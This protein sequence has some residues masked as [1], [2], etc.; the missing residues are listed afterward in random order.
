MAERTAPW[1]LDGVATGSQEARLFTE[2]LLDQVGVVGANDLKVSAPGGMNVSIAAGRAFIRDTTAY[3]GAYHVVADSATTR[4]VSAANATNP[5]RD[6]V[7]AEVTATS[8]QT[9]VVAGVAAASPVDPA[10]PVDAIVLARVTVP[11]AAAAITTA[12]IEDLRSF[13]SPIR[14]LLDRRNVI[15]NGDMSIWQRGA[16]SFTAQGYCADGW[17]KEHAG[18]TVSVGRTYLAPNVLSATRY[19]LTATV[20]GQAAATDYAIIGQRI[21]QVE[22]L[23]GKQVTISFIANATSAAKVALEALQVFGTGGAPSA[24]VTTPLGV[25][26]IGTAKARYAVTVTIPSIVGKSLG[27]NGDDYLAIRLYLSGGASTGAQGIG[28]QN[29]T[30]DVTDFQVEEGPVATPFERLPYQQQLAWCQRYFYRFIPNTSS[31][32]YGF[33]VASGGVGRVGW[34]HP[35]QMRAVPTVTFVGAATGWSIIRPSDGAV[36]DPN[37][38]YAGAGDIYGVQWGFD[39]SGNL[40]TGVSFSW[41]SDNG[42]TNYIDVTAEL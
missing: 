33:G 2:S 14:S 16:G 4:A 29:L 18:G 27:A 17:L 11:A 22:T 20:A 19:A 39:S 30:F 24:V 35:V 12:M 5:R 42:S 1:L 21:E 8:W 6:L 36:V 38:V 34:R 32:Q 41:Y 10:V 23:A 15:R 3:Q 28:I 40:G 25:V 37:S 13:A 7:I 9:R 26:P 31:G